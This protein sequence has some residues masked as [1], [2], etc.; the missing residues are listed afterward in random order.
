MTRASPALPVDFFCHVFRFHAADSPVVFAAPACHVVWNIVSEDHEDR[1]FRQLVEIPRIDAS[2]L[3]APKGLVEINGSG[4]S[5]SGKRNPTP[6]SKAM[7]PLT[8]SFFM[9]ARSLRRLPA[10]ASR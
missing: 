6:G 4:T 5:S 8:L 10:N 9:A 7:M 1:D 3:R 2:A